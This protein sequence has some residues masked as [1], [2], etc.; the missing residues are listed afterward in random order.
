MMKL[1][2]R[3]LASTTLI[4]LL[5]S[6]GL[7]AIMHL[8]PGQFCGIAAHL[9]APVVMGALPFRTLWLIARRGNL[10]VGQSAPDFEI[11]R[12][13]KTGSVRLSSH[14]GQRPVVLI[15]GSYT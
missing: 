5:A 12:Q 8:P 10:H 13:D 2:L 9:P 3:L 15:F 14:R 11:P 1:L 6:A 4:W 7:F